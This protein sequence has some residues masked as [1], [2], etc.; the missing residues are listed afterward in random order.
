[1]HDI[2]SPYLPFL[3]KL[4]HQMLGMMIDVTDAR[5]SGDGNKVKSIVYLAYLIVMKQ[6]QMDT[7]EFQLDALIA[8]GKH[9][10]IGSTPLKINFFSS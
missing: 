1:M 7:F 5:A 4:Q 3:T 6:E 2:P 10:T 9:A 8:G